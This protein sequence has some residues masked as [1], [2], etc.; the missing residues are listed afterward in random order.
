MHAIIVNAHYH[1]QRA[2][3][4]PSSFHHL[5]QNTRACMHAIIVNAH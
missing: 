4:T 2:H 3:A 1:Q 5:V